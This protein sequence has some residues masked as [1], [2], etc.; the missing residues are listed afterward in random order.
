MI[1]VIELINPLNHI[2]KKVLEMRVYADMVN[3][4]VGSQTQNFEVEMVP[5]NK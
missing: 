1:F 4:R 2:L 3:I 5:V